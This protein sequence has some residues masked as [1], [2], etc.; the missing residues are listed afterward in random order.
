MQIRKLFKAEM[1]HMVPGAYTERC[2]FLHGH[3]Y[4]F[5]LFLNGPHPNSA[6]MV[7]DFKAIKDMGINDFFDSFDHSVMMWKKDPL[8]PMAA[9]INPKR[10]IVVPF[11]PTAEMIAKACFVV[12]QAILKTSP[13]LSGEKEVTIEKVVVHETDTGYGCFGQS[14]LKSDKFPEI[15]FDTWTISEGIQRDWKNKKWFSNVLGVLST[16]FKVLV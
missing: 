2:H 11:I 10:H 12:C 4:K 1:A 16:K 7:A 13:P 8:A 9:K 6:S 3:S 14:D 15:E 5:E